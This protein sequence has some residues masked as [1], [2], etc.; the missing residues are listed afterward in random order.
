MPAAHP[1]PACGFLVHDARHGSGATCP[2]CGWIDDFEQLAHPD[3]TYG[4]NAGLSL[5][6]AQARSLEALATAPAARAATFARDAR[7]R[8]LRAGETPPA[9]PD[10]P[11]SPVCYV[12]TPDPGEFV[13]Y[14]RRGASR[15]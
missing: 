13:P 7:W 3:L 11:A 14:W 12:G 9:D 15:R 10:G 4:A 8:P 6:Q 5:R 2:V 1:C